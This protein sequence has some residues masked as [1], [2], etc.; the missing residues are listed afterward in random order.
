MENLKNRLARPKYMDVDKWTELK[1]TQLQEDWRFKLIL[2]TV[3]KHFETDFEKM[4]MLVRVRKDVFPR[5]VL[6][7]LIQKHLKN[8]TLDIITSLFGQTHS[9]A[10][11]ANKVMD[12]L[13]VGDKTTFALIEQIDN[14]IKS[15]RTSHIR[16]KSNVFKTLLDEMVLDDTEKEKWLVEYVKAV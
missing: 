15:Y 8:Y 12:N 2:A 7:Y 13:E 9:M 16:H 14:E 3:E 1:T 5:Q 11:H 6:V 10:I 4:K